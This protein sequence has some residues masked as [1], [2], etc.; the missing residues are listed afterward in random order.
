MKIPT[1]MAMAAVLGLLLSACGSSPHASRQALLTAQSAFQQ[2][3]A[4]HGLAAA[5][6]QYAGERAVFLPN[7]GAI[8]QGGAAIAAA[9]AQQNHLQVHW[10]GDEARIGASGDF[11]STWGTYIASTDAGGGRRVGYGKFLAVWGKQDGN[12]RVVAFMV[13]ASPGAAVESR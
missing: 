6:K 3:A 7:G 8:V 10:V 11:G 2:A 9:L 4:A 1:R 12:W 5:F 13:N